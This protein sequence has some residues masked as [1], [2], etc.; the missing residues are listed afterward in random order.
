MLRKLTSLVI[1]LLISFTAFSQL[2]S[3]ET[4]Y[5]VPFTEFHPFG[6]LL[7]KDNSFISV[8]SGI[9]AEIDHYGFAQNK[10]I[11]PGGSVGNPYY[12]QYFYF[13]KVDA[14]GDAFYLA[15]NR[16]SI[17][18]N[19]MYLHTVF[20]DGTIG[21]TEYLLEDNL[22]NHLKK[23]PA[24]VKTNEGDF[25]IFGNENYYKVSVENA[26]T[27]NPVWTKPGNFGLIA[28]ADLY[29]DGFILCN[30]D[31][32]LILLDENGDPVW[33]QNLGFRLMAVQT[34]SD[35]FMICGQIDEE[36]ALIKT[37]L[38]GNILWQKKYGESVAYD[39]TITDD[40]EIVFTGVSNDEQVFVVK[41][42]ASGNEIWHKY[43][44]NG[45]GRKILE[46]RYGGFLIQGKSS[47]KAVLKRISAD[48][49]EGEKMYF[50]INGPRRIT[51][52]KISAT[53]NAGGKHF[54]LSGV[55]WGGFDIS[56]SYIFPKGAETSSLTS[57]GLWMAGLDDENVLHYTGSLVTQ[58]NTGYPYQGGY[59]GADPEAWTK[60]WSVNRD[61]IKIVRDDIADG[62]KDFPWAEDMIT[63]PGTGNPNYFFN[64]EQVEIPE[65]MAPF[66]DV[67][68]D[69]IYNV[70]DGDYPKIKGDD[71]LWWVMND[72]TVRP[73][74]QGLPFGIQIFCS[75]YSI[76]CVDD[77]LIN[78]ATFLEM[79]I[80]NLSQ[81]N[82]SDFY[83][84]WASALRIGCL[85]DDYVGS[86]PEIN[87]V[88][89]YNADEVDGSPEGCSH[90]MTSFTEQPPIQTVM[91]LNR[92]AN[93]FMTYSDGGIQP[94][95]Y[96][97]TEDPGNAN[98]AH[99]I[100]QAKF[101]DGLPMTE[102]G[103]GHNYPSMDYTNIA[104][105]GNPALDDE[106]SGC[107]ESL[108]FQHRR[109]VMSQKDLTLQSRD[110]LS[111]KVAFLTLDDIPQ[112][113]PDADL[114][115]ARIS[116]LKDIYN[117]S[118]FSYFLDLGADTTIFEGE[119]I[120]L[121]AGIGGEEY[122]WS[123]GETS[124][125]IEV[126]LPGTYSVT[127]STSWGCEF[128]DEVEVNV[129]VS[130]KNIERS[131]L[132]VYPNPTSG[133][134]FIE[135]ENEVPENIYLENII[136]QRLKSVQVPDGSE[137]TNFELNIPDAN[138]G[139]YFLRFDYG[140]GKQALQKLVILK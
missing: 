48:G 129:T 117:V 92:E 110:Q 29:D 120:T 128:V 107:A 116:A 97:G 135:L 5:N 87:A 86:L 67:N 78:Y 53:A 100:L 76:G 64:G 85:D 114:I 56:R 17:T 42:D 91:L 133:Q 63:W 89:V 70:F 123:T 46:S 81:N 68:G 24:A 66:V 35:G 111:L 49:L 25:V 11:L 94:P 112:P 58:V 106:W 93:I 40:G 82:Y 55:T 69:G 73:A 50:E 84:G 71:M 15:A 45:Q 74:N 90:D 101:R 28:D 75:F 124:S 99:Y 26:Q 108:D 22:L 115:A 83:L 39:L 23:G 137:N 19:E 54:G 105:P 9:F 79:D 121:D 14:P 102:G 72:E 140:N 12:M 131:T 1:T 127:V 98:E 43:Y 134:I 109:M 18:S 31:G 96:P 30:E 61:M 20:E 104:F 36:S 51:A 52:N 65:D 62:V 33:N 34:V 125:S 47:N 130:N 139:V 38:L 138:S 13:E 132:K 88:Y 95:P 27:I 21:L 57:A 126:S 44:G 103:N 118:D 8:T 60:A 4:N 37:D 136:G 119:I 59:I 80:H 16:L 41:T 113:C 10:F 7:E 3:W 2:P 6:V 77:D 32:N 122:Q